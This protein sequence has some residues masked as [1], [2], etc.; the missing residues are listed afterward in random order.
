VGRVTVNTIVVDV[1]DAP[2]VRP[3]DE[4]VLYGRQGRVEI[5]Q[6]EV[7][8]QSGSILADLYTIWG[9]SNPRV[10]VSD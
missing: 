10:L 3:G 2:E 5:T 6:E 7:E 8:K 1:T 9:N 4:V